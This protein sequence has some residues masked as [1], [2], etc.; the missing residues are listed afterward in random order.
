MRPFRK[1][2]TLGAAVISVTA[3]TDNAVTEPALQPGAVLTLQGDDVARESPGFIEQGRYYIK[4]SR[5]ADGACHY[6]WPTITVAPGRVRRESSIELRRST[7]EAIVAHREDASSQ[8]ANTSGSVAALLIDGYDSTSAA[9]DLA[10]A[11]AAPTNGVGF[12]HIFTRWSIGCPNFG[13]ETASR[14]LIA[15]TKDNGCIQTA[16]IQNYAKWR[17]GSVTIFGWGLTGFTYPTHNNTPCGTM[18]VSGT[19]REDGGSPD[20][21]GWFVDIYTDYNV[22]DVYVRVSDGYVTAAANATISTGTCDL[23]WDRIV[24]S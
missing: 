21:C 18:E 24:G 6:Q 14:V 7:C 10:Y 1:S 8:T 12:Q 17:K 9:A 2:V 11:A 13:E 16:R 19:S 23:Y 4:G 5:T 3:C 20:D 15:Y 22:N